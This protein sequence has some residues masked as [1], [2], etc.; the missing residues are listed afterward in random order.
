MIETYELCTRDSRILLHNQLATTDFADAIDY[1]PYR[2]FDH[3]DDRVWSNLMSGDWAWNE[4]VCIC[5]HLMN[6]VRGTNSNLRLVS[7][8]INVRMDLC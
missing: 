5:Q 1:K 4:A 3:R 7:L 6:E 8:K 2:Q